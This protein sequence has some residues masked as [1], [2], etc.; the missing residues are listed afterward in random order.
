MMTK[1]KGMSLRESRMDMADAIL[2]EKKFSIS[3][4]SIKGNLA[5]NVR[6]YCQVSLDK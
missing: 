3:C 4:Q 6:N 2:N 5:E 1:I